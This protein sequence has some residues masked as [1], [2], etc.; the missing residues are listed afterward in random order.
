MK[1][2]YQRIRRLVCKEFFVTN[3]DLDGPCRNS[4]ISEARMVAM[5]LIFEHTDMSKSHV[6]YMFGKRGQTCVYNAKRRV[7][8]LY[9]VD[10]A[11]RRKYNRVLSAIIPRSDDNNDNNDKQS[12]ML[13]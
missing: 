1:D 5:K 13:S 4:H 12:D 6:S 7:S 2:L 8:M 11:F 10:P 9:D 3:K